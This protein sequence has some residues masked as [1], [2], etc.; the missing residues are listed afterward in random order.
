MQVCSY[1][2]GHVFPFLELS[3]LHITHLEKKIWEQPKPGA[4]M[5]KTGTT[6]ALHH[7][8]L[9]SWPDSYDWL[10]RKVTTSLISDAVMQFLMQLCSV[11]GN[12]FSPLA[13]LLFKLLKRFTTALLLYWILLRPLL[14]CHCSLC[15]VWTR[16]PLEWISIGSGYLK[17]LFYLH[18]WYL[19]GDVMWHLDVF[20]S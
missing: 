3:L 5:A 12:S 11:V 16:D 2:S 9:S 15:V 18:S 19:L 17:L 7:W 10:T 1:T 14:E 6:W 13:F 20:H 4:Q 8:S